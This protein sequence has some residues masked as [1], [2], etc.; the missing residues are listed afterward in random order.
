MLGCSSLY[1]ISVGVNWGRR[2]VDTSM[3]NPVIP[4]KVASNLR[5]RHAHHIPPY[6]GRIARDTILD[7][8][9]SGSSLDQ[10]RKRHVSLSSNKIGR[11]VFTG[12]DRKEEFINKE[13]ERITSLFRAFL[14]LSFRRRTSWNPS[15]PSRSFQIGPAGYSISFGAQVDLPYLSPFLSC[16][17]SWV[18]SS[19]FLRPSC[20]AIYAICCGVCREKMRRPQSSPSSLAYRACTSP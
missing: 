11:V 14:P 16:R 1:H 9:R 4:K 8:V 15:S 20:F 17:S 13:K 12:L 7:F 10:G 6:F 5:R 19:I 18:P 2:R 3:F